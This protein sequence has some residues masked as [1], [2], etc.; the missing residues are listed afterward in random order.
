MKYVKVVLLVQS[1]P[2]NF[3]KSLEAV[4]TVPAAPEAPNSAVASTLHPF[5]RSCGD[6]VVDRTPTF[7]PR[8]A[9]E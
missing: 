7:T 8:L 9:S 5:S 2:V 1:W 6:T 4:Q 3:E